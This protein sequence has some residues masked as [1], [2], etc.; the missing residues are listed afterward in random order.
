MVEPDRDVTLDDLNDSELVA[1]CNWMDIRASRAWPRK[2][3]IWVLEN[4]EP[5]EVDQPLDDERGIMSEYLKLYWEKYRLQVDKKVCPNC[6][7][8]RDLQ[9]MSCYNKNKHR[10]G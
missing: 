10:V 5:I 2:L 6:S 7:E 1:L 3:L 9:I 8:C 4:F